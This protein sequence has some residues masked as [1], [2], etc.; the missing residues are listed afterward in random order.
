VARASAE[1]VANFMM[2]VFA[3]E[4]TEGEA[5]RNR[6]VARKRTVQ[7]A[8]D[9][10]A[11][12]IEGRFGDRPEVEAAVRHTIGKTYFE[13]GAL[14]EAEPQIVR[15]LE[16]RERTLGPDH[17]DTLRS[18]HGLAALYHSRGRYEEAETLSKRAIAGRERTLGP[19]HPDTL[20]A[21][22]N[23]G[24]LYLA[25]KRFADAVP[26]LDRAARGFAKRPE[27]AGA[28]PVIRAE[29]GLALL[30][31]GKPADAE[32]Y[33]LAGSDALSKRK[34]L[35]DRNLLRWATAGLVEVYEQT[36]QPEKAK[37]W[38]AKFAELPPEVAPRRGRRT[39]R[40]AGRRRA[41]LLPPPAGAPPDEPVGVAGGEGLAVGRERHREE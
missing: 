26:L 9:Q 37:Q 4:G 10:A 32:P 19:D 1:E 20:T 21:V 5:G 11:K 16:L 38:R 22:S 6:D 31:D 17:P 33:L 25:M 29:L 2:V 34:A 24:Y 14:A 23:L 30:G 41:E 36:N 28:V 40:I 35:G 3:G 13:I 12:M 18:V 27:M 39:D 15:A 8:M 7:E